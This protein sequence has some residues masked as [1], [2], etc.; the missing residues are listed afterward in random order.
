MC[1]DTDFNPDQDTG[2][3]GVR[4]GAIINIRIPQRRII[5]WP[6]KQPEASKEGR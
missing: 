1:E 2:Q 5:C 6:D 4:V 3:W